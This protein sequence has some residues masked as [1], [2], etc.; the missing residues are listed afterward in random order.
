VEEFDSRDRAV[1]WRTSGGN[2]RFLLVDCDRL[3][4]DDVQAFRDAAAALLGASVPLTLEH[5]LAE[6]A[7]LTERIARFGDCH[8]ALEI[9][10]RLG[11]D[12][13]ERVGDMEAA[14]MQ[15]LLAHNTLELA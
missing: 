4:E 7:L 9:W 5:L 11:V 8:D 3:V 2:L 15:T 10:Q 1:V 12:H 13:P 14:H 6:H